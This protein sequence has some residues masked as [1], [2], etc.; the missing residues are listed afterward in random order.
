VN[1]QREH[2]IEILRQA[3]TLLE[4]ENT[5]LIKRTLELEREVLTLKGQS[6]EALQMRLV[7]LEAML[8]QHQKARFGQKSEKQS[9]PSAAKDKAAQT[10][11]GPRAQVELPIEPVVYALD[12]AD[13]PCPECGAELC[14]WENQFEESEEIERV[15]RR[16]FVRRDLR[17]KYKCGCGHIETALG[18]DKLQAGARYSVN[19]AVDVATDKY[20]DHIPLERQARIMSREGLQIDSQTL[21]DQIERLA[22]WLQ[23]LYEAL[24]AYVLAQRVIG[25]DE[26]HWRMLSA[27]GTDK[28]ANK[29]WQVWT[30]C[31]DNAVAYKILDSRSTEAAKIAL[32]NFSGIAMCDGYAVYNRLS[33][34]NPSLR[35]ANCFAHVRRKFIEAEDDY[36]EQAG[37]ALAMI[38]ELYAVEREAKETGPPE[39]L[40]E[41]REALRRDKSYPIMLRLQAWAIAQRVLPQSTIGKALSYLHEQWRGLQVYLDDTHVHIDN[42]ATERA[43]RGVVVGRKNHYGSK[44]ER[45]TQVAAI[46]YSLIES[47]KLNGLHPERYLHDATIAA[48]RGELAPLPHQVKRDANEP[49]HAQADATI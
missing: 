10:G 34:E 13:R 43:I 24:R 11:H 44:S 42:N 17:Q 8:T 31:S 26:T 20:C 4:N 28:G 35:I 1:I 49:A 6:P 46:F 16:F 2:D 29:R 40:H 32:E 3:A 25:V 45:G 7:A 33:K 23:P 37:T 21:W 19:F 15:S 5:K 27:K 30:V 41:R 9:K 38:A 18:P 22:R 36:A 14:A 12:E 47:C 39:T 48:I